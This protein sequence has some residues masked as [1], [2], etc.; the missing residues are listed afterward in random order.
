VNYI[1]NTNELKLPKQ[2]PTTEYRVKKREFVIVRHQ[3]TL[4][5]PAYSQFQGLNDEKLYMCTII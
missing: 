4:L 2:K 5:A 3:F 1:S